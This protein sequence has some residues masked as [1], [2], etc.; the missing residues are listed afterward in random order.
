MQLVRG[1]RQALAWFQPSR[2]E[3][4]DPSE[5]PVFNLALDDEHFYGFP[6]YG[7]PGFKLGRYDH[8]GAGGG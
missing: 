6:V 8:F 5:F 4:F 3:L 7:I 2:P 1:V